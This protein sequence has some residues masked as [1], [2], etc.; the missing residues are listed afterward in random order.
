MLSRAARAIE[1]LN[2]TISFYNIGGA[3]HDVRQE[4]YTWKM[5][6]T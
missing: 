5:A 4:G 6:Q 1:N 2:P 3:S